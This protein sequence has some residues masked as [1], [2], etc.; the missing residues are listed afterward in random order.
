MFHN[1]EQRTQIWVSLLMKSFNIIFMY[2]T[3][4]LP[5]KNILIKN[6]KCCLSKQGHVIGTQ[7]SDFPY[8]VKTC[9]DTVY[10]Y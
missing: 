4:T 8:H 10:H 9:K 5:L 1:F 7:S 2:Y 3:F 6:N